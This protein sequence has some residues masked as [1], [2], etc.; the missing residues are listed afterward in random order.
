MNPTDMRQFWETKM[1]HDKGELSEKI[2]DARKKMNNTLDHDG[3]VAEDHYVKGK[4]R[5][6]AADCKDCT[7]GYYGRLIEWPESEI[8]KQFLA[9]NMEAVIEKFKKAKRET[10]REA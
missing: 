7:I 8:T 9:T 2:V 4:A 10:N 3:P 5:K 6:I 1:Y